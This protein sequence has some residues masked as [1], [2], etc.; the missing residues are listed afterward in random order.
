MIVMSMLNY[1]IKSK[2]HNH[3]RLNQ[4]VGR[5]QLRVQSCRNTKWNFK[6]S[7]NCGYD[8]VF[9]YKN[10]K[11]LT[12]TDSGDGLCNVASKSVNF[13]KYVTFVTFIYFYFLSCYDFLN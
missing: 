2:Q 3:V 6:F 11:L 12:A 4:A 1:A 5:R 10:M 7:M 9:K 13:S 8:F